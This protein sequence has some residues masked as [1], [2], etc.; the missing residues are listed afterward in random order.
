M[1]QAVRAMDFLSSRYQTLLTSAQPITQTA[2][3]TI[4]KLA[5]RLDPTCALPDRRAAVLSLKGL[6]RDEKYKAEIGQVALGPLVDVVLLGGDAEADAES[7]KA[8]LETL[9]LL[10]EVV[11]GE[12]GK[13]AKGDVGYKHTDALLAVSVQFRF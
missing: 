12:N 6:A 3:S 8:V 2:D 10:C 9:G 1:S 5:G 11:P 7:G 4:H 13:I